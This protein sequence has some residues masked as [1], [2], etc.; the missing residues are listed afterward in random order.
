[1]AGA[2]GMWKSRQRFPRARGQRWKTCFWFS[3]LS[4]PRHFRSPVVSCDS[5]LLEAGKKVPLRFLHAQSGAGVSLFSGTKFEFFRRDL[6]AQVSGHARQL[7]EYFPW[8]GIPAVDPLGLATFVRLQFRNSAWPVKVQVRIEV[9]D[10]ENVN[11]L[12][13]LR[14]NMVEPHVFADDR[15]V[16]RFHQP[17]VV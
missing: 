1:M 7:P 8:R 13:M 10:I 9:L 12:R 4:T 5:L 2:A 11:P 6:F 17:V 3:S 16:F 15:S 14:S